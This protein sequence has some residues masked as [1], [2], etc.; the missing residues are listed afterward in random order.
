[1]DSV[2]Q[3]S[4]EYFLTCISS[5]VMERALVRVCFVVPNLLQDN[6]NPVK[7]RRLG[8]EQYIEQ[9]ENGCIW[10]WDVQALKFSLFGHNVFDREAGSGMNHQLNSGDLEQSR[11]QPLF[12]LSNDS[13]GC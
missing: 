7:R 9:S 12:P 13:N 2:D 6:A 11:P 3:D 10:P 8:Q 4:V 1:M 5:G